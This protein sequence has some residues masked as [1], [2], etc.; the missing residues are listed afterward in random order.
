M[1]FIDLLPWL[2][3]GLLGFAV[4]TF[5]TLVG[6]GG[7]FLLV[8]VL[9]LLYPSEA[10]STIT[11][12]SLAVVFLNATS[13]SIAYAR[14][15]RIDYRTGLVFAAAGAPGAIL[16]ARAT[17]LLPRGVFD[18][19]FG[20]AL[21]GLAT[22]LLLR[23][24][25]A[26]GHA[27]PERVNLPVGAAL[28]FGVGFLSSVL[29]IGGGV[30]HVP[31]LIQFLGYPAHIAT[32]T[33]HFILAIMSLVGTLTHIVDGEFASGIRR[34]LALGAGVLVGAQVGAQLS[35]R[36]QGPLILRTLAVGILLVGTRLAASVV[37][38]DPTAFQPLAQVGQQ[39][40][41]DEGLVVTARP[42]APNVD[43]LVA[44]AAYVATPLIIGL[45]VLLVTRAGNRPGANPATA[46]RALNGTEC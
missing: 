32:A 37:I 27:A 41:L 6:A 36:V 12:I 9:L 44:L 2:G 24:R 33:S 22:Y 7:G 26:D 21:V 17:G 31:L 18:M 4:G 39:L 35:R 3:L 34:T 30:I 20:L 42:L 38:A 45:V 11:A 23:G 13:G 25:V 15:K 40:A 10:V 14:L 16:G 46:D 8:P 43:D 1:T 28:S 5:G 19:V 29:G